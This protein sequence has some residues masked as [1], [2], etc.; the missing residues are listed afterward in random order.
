MGSQV[1]NELDPLERILQTLILVLSA[2]VVDVVNNLFNMLGFATSVTTAALGKILETLE[3]FIK[4]TF[5]LAPHRLAGSWW[6]RLFDFDIANNKFSR[7]SLDEMN[8]DRR[9]P[10]DEPASN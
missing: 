2:F 7:G 5:G 1:E 3:K 8:L 9:D 10:A 6:L 4:S